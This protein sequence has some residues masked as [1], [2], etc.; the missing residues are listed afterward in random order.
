MKTQKIEE[1]NESFL[2]PIKDIFTSLSNAEQLHST[3]SHAPTKSALSLFEKT[4]YDRQ[5]PIS[6]K[7]QEKKRD[8]AETWELKILETGQPIT[9]WG[10]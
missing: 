3:E 9:A 7:S 6:N 10:L 4:P 2:K 5:S 1:K 8:E